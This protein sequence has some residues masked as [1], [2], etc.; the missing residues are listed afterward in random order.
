MLLLAAIPLL[1]VGGLLFLIGVYGIGAASLNESKT[2]R[3]ES[4]DDG[5]VILFGVMLVLA[6][7][8]PLYIAAKVMS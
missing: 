1:L 6:S 4:A 3:F 7:S 5:T 8:L 2:P